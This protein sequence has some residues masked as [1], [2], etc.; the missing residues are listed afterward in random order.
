MA[1][2]KL[3]KGKNFQADGRMPMTVTSAIGD[4]KNYGFNDLANS[5]E[6]QEGYWLLYSDANFQ[7]KSVL[8]GP[9]NYPDFSKIS[10]NGLSSLRP[11]PDVDG[12][13]LR[14]F[15]DSEFR[16][17]M[18]VFTEEF[19]NFEWIGFN[20][21]TSSALVLNGSWDL[22]PKANYEGRPWSIDTDGD[23]I[24]IYKNPTH[25]GNNQVSSVRPA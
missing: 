7:G 25:F 6:V 18:V 10:M 14:L 9:H 12:P 13:T 8:L 11:L 24:G 23:K 21:E 2:I 1:T 3:F 22:F 15:S 16:A 19:Q 17:R 20:D 4:L 5:C